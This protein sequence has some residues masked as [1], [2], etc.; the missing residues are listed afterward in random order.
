MNAAPSMSALA[1]DS[2]AAVIGSTALLACAFPVTFDPVVESSPAG[3]G[4]YAGDAPMEYRIRCRCCGAYGSR[5][6]SKERAASQWNMICRM[7]PSYRRA[8]A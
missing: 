6:A 8:N 2:H 5:A 3:P 1:N 4:H 7:M